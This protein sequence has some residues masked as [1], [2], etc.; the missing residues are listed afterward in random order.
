MEQ[1]INKQSFI[2]INTTTILKTTSK[3]A[4]QTIT[5]DVKIPTASL[6]PEEPK[7]LS[8][9]TTIDATKATEPLANSLTICLVRS[10]SR[11]KTSRKPAI[12]K[13]NKVT[14]KIKEA[15]LL[16]CRAWRN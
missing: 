12:P 15:R 14:F 5:V 1:E 3:I 16:S 13:P 2:D 11:L 6:H 7:R 8:K 10:F 9:N 4:R